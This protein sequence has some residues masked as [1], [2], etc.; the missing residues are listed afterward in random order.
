M[1]TQEDHLHI[2]TAQLPAS[3]P[4]SSPLLT[5]TAAPSDWRFVLTQEDLSIE[6]TLNT[7]VF[8]SAVKLRL[9]DS[10]NYISLDANPYETVSPSELAFSPSLMS[11]PP[12]QRS[13]SESFPMGLS[14]PP[15]FPSS[16]PIADTMTLT[17]LTNLPTPPVS[18][19]RASIAKDVKPF[20]CD[21]CSSS[22]SRNHDLKRH[23]RIHLGI[24]PFSCATCHKSFTRMDA[25]HRHTNVRG[26][27]GTDEESGSSGSRGPVSAI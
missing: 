25:L 2:A 26:C 13:K 27:K 8:K 5:P 22:F 10:Y 17:N 18:V 16:N 7:P 3:M 14:L 1:Q 15:L 9:D 19:R 4:Y 11:P 6:S 21:M 20:R 12:R 24:R 23:V